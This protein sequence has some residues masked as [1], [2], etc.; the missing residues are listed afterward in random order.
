MDW[1]DLRSHLINVHGQHP[2]GID[3]ATGYVDGTAGRRKS[4]EERHHLLHGA[5]LQRSAGA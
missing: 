1:P 5:N 4:A 3:D 2:E